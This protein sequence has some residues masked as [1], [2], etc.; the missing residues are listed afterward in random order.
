MGAGVVEAGA[1]SC[2][3]KAVVVGARVEAE[4]GVETAAFI[5]VGGNVAVEI[6]LALAVQVGFGPPLLLLL[7]LSSSL[8]APPLSV[9]P[10]P[11]PSLSP[12]SFLL[13][14]C[15]GVSG[16]SESSSS[17]SSSSSE[18]CFCGCFCAGLCG[19]SGS[20]G[21]DGGSGTGAGASGSVGALG[22][23]AIVA[24]F[25]AGGGSPSWG[26]LGI[27]TATWLLRLREAS[28]FLFLPSRISSTRRGSIAAAFGLGER[29]FAAT[30]SLV[31]PVMPM[32]EPINNSAVVRE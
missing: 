20:V 11:S 30:R 6:H 31:C 9:S 22:G 25:G 15:S 2:T 7:T 24:G 1:S 16:E 10:S 18:S 8:S 32:E 4:V 3:V 19:P 14:G 26:A 17:S 23:L 27:T 5:V 13:L 28:S 29:R 21:A 12:L